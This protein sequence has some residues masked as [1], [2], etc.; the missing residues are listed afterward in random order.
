MKNIFGTGV[1]LI[2]PM[3]ADNS[4][5]LESLKRLTAH[6]IEGGVD[7]IVA[8]GTT[9]EAATLSLEEKQEVLQTIK[10]E[11]RDRL[12][13][14]LS[15]GGNNTY[16]LIQEAKRLNYSD[17]DALLSVC[18]YYVKPSQQGL[19]QHYKTLSQELSIPIIL[20]NVPG[21]TGVNLLPE[22][23]L[24]L[25]REC[26]NIF[27]IKEACGDVAQFWELLQDAPKDF[28]A[29][30]GDDASTLATTFLGGD[31]AISVLAQAF[32]KEFSS[33][34]RK[35]RSGKVQQANELNRFLYPFIPLIF[36]EGNPV[37]I[38]NLLKILGIIQ[39]D[40]TRLP[41]V[42]ATQRLEEKIKGLCNK[43][44]F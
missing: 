6:I 26:K 16:E 32:P 10:E 15:V 8:L 41:L 22:T 11:N 12:P 31:G 5:D 43:V 40:Q 34:I 19:Y 25:A 7:Y 37:G 18:P 4:L 35:A 38:K 1:A 21:R 20:Y 2:S 36:E 39:S 33:M 14:V 23:S 29:I 44:N 9:S 17:Y 3:R 24:S 42:R 28:K 13:V 30:S 27:G